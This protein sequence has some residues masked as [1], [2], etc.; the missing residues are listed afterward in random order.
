VIIRMIITIAPIRGASESAERLP[1]CGSE[2]G[3]VV[4]VGHCGQPGED[5]AQICERVFSE[6]LAGDDDRVNDRG[7]LTSTGVPNKQPVLFPD[8]GRPDRV[9]DEVVVETGLMMPEV[10]GERSPVTEQIRA[11]FPEA[12]AGQHLS[13]QR[14]REPAQPVQRPGKHRLP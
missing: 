6:A 7:A 2:G 3:E 10:F 9:F 11:G 12:G 8:R 4:L 13:L 1:A 5:I 14:E